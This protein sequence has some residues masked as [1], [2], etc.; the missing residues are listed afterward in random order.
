MDVQSPS[1][2][3]TLYLERTKFLQSSRYITF[4]YLRVSGCFLDN[5]THAAYHVLRFAKGEIFGLSFQEEW[6]VLGA[7]DDFVLT[8]YVGNN[9]QDTLSRGQ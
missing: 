3:S 5:R 7:D 9:L 8:A 2:R 1:D 4:G 6:Y